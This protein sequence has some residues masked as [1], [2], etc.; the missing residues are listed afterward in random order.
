M[1]TNY[2]HGGFGQ[3]FS[4]YILHFTGKVVILCS[5]R[6]VYQIMNLIITFEVGKE[7]EVD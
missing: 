7:E 4:F 6:T 5:N 2:G 1:L 3:F